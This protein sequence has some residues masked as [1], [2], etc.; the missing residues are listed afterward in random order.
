MK[1]FS[2]TLG[3]K[4]MTKMMNTCGC[5]IKNCPFCDGKSVSFKN[6]VGR[7]NVRCTECG[8]AQTSFKYL[9]EE[10]AIADWNERKLINNL[11][12]H[13]TLLFRERR[14]SKILRKS[15][16]ELIEEVGWSD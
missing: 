9:T 6:R 3:K 11:R 5:A 14:S 16:Y 15:I 1:N 7:W 10:E 12:E 4:M 13:L 8:M 2:T